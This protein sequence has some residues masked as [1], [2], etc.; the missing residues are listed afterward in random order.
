MTDKQTEPTRGFLLL[1][2]M[3]GGAVGAALGLLY[4]PRPGADVRRELAERSEDFV[5][6]ARTA[7]DAA[8][9]AREDAPP[10]PGD[11]PL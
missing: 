1:G 7:A 3:L 6:R 8:R 5:D 10:P 11:T 4:A 9:G 2:L